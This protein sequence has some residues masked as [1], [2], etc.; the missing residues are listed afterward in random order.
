MTVTDA[1]GA[2][3]PPVCQLSWTLRSPVVA[4][5]VS[6]GAVTSYANGALVALTVLPALSMQVAD[7]VPADVLGPA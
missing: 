1:S 7:R 2:R 5:A 6:A 4:A 3:S